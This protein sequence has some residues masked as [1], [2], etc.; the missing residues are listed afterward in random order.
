MVLQLPTGQATSAEEWSLRVDLAACYRLVALF[1]WDDLV[2]T[3]ISA[4]LPGK[5]EFLI[6][7]YGMTFDEMTASSLVKVD[8]DG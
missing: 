7:P 3:H 2:G 4:R 5:E 8:R 1:G 6:N